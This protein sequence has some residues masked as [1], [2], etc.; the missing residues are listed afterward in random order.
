MK[1]K[2]RQLDQIRPVKIRKNFINHPEGSVLIS[3]GLTQVICNASLD[4]EVPKFLRDTGKGWVTAEYAMLPRSTHTRMV[5]ESIK[6]KPSGRTQEISRLVGRALRSVCDR[7]LLGER[8]IVVDCDVIQADGGTRCASINGGY[9]ALCL[10]VKKLL[11]QGVLKKDPI[12]GMVAAISVGIVNGVATLD[13]NYE[14]DSTAEVDMNFVM[15]DRGHFVEVQGTAEHCAFTDRQL[16]VMKR[17]AWKGIQQIL[18]A[19]G[20]QLA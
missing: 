7:E 10:A 18:Q 2:T 12:R 9:I 15:T 5:R 20:R 11:Q 17:L 14:Q 1:P 19:Q 8:Q 4:E 13:L 3:Q 6:G 16:E